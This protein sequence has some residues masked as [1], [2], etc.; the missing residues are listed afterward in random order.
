MR[1]TCQISPNPGPEIIQA[2]AS[3][4]ARL[5]K[6]ATQFNAVLQHLPEEGVTLALLCNSD[7]ALKAPGRSPHGVA[8]RLFQILRADTKAR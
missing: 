4:V 8:Q 6:A 2:A 7:T 1:I 5:N 3:P